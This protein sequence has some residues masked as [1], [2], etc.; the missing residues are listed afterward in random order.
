MR[1]EHLRMAR[2]R[3]FIVDDAS[4]AVIYSGPWARVDAADAAQG[5]PLVDGTLHEISAPGGLA[6]NFTGDYRTLMR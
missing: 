3:I 2:S 1:R 4:A 5:A 6:F